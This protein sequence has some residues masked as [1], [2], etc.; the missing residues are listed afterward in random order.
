MF[1][2]PSGRMNSRERNLYRRC[3]TVFAPGLA[4]SALVLV[5][6]SGFLMPSSLLFAQEKPVL[7][8]AT[9]SS[10]ESSGLLG[11]LIPQFEEQSN[12]DVRLRIVGSGRALKEA[13]TGKQDMVWVHAPESEL[14]F[15]EEGYAN[16]R[17]QI[18]RNDFVLI[19]PKSDPAKVRELDDVVVAFNAIYATESLFTSRGDDSGTHKRERLLW[20]MAGVDPVALEWYTET[21]LGMSATLD[22]S[23]QNE[24]YMLIDRAT[25]VRRGAANLQILLDGKS[26]LENVYSVLIVSADKVQGVNE[27]LANTFLAWLLSEVAK[28]EIENFESRGQRLFSYIG[29]DSGMNTGLDYKESRIP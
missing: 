18:M 16:E 21:G 27:T 5:L 8:L 14:K 29:G 2:R 19:G 1:G 20:S 12:T 28:E 3:L 11:L 25:F 23:Q 10:L 17:H 15:V 22:I 13:R 9:T 7:R 6:C 26:Q 4:V 24:T